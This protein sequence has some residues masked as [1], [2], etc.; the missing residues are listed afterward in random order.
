M[1]LGGSGGKLAIVYAE[2]EIVDGTG[3]DQEFIW[4]AKLAREIRMLR[5]DD[6]VKAVVLRVNSP[7]GS[8]SASEA[9]QRELR[10]TLKEKPVVVSMGTVAASGGYWISTYSDRIFAEP[11]TITGSI[12]VFGMFLNIQGLATDKLGLTFDMVK[13]G[14]FADLAS[15]ARPKTD[16]ELAI[17]Q[18]IVDWSY[19]QFLTKVAESR[20]L[21]R[22]AVQEI[23]Q[24]RVWSGAEAKK[25][26]LV[27]ELG[28]LDAALK[29]AAGKAGLG[30]Q[31]HVVE[32]PRKKLFAEAISE[33]FEGRR[34]DSSSAGALDGFVRQVTAGLKAL[35]HF[36]D[37]QGVY[38]RL[39]LDQA[40]P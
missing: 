9:I 24:G 38:A 33:A 23:A 14:K 40:L 5:L 11:T 30:D 35:A 8:A 28:G 36:N 31:F 18:R 4:G 29:F 20:K 21:D 22:A 13:T 25:L 7:G 6:S 34:H 3:N 15:I 37:P 10:L 12:G 2:G 26:G 16:E 27:D 1:D 32:V 39:P 19:G 17:F